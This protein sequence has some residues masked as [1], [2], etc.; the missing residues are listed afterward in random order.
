MPYS[1]S[2]KKSHNKAKK[3]LCGLNYFRRLKTIN[4][5]ETKPCKQYLICSVHWNM[6]LINYLNFLSLP[7]QAY[8]LLKIV[9]TSTQ[10]A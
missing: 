4:L 6:Y 8:E 9:C 10:S 7:T 5:I 3:F 1:E 2:N